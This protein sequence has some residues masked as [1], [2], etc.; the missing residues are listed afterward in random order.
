MDKRVGK[1]KELVKKE[2]SFLG[3]DLNWF[4]ETHLLAVEKCAKFLLQKLPKADKDLVMLLVWLHDLQRVRQI[5]GDHEKI[6]A[7]E[8]EKVMKDFDYN[9]E[10]IEKVKNA[11]LCH[12]CKTRMP[13][14]LEEKILATAD[15]MSQ[16]YNGF[17]LKI[18]LT[19]QRNFEEYK[20][21]LIEKLKRN[22]NKKIFFDFARKEIKPRHE[23]FKK[24][25]KV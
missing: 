17:F 11:I 16:Y 21:W 1:I 9:N 10:T 25:T 13:K 3:K 6:G 4:Y 8:A 20:E 23:F 15:A 24:L 12:R 22:Y 5:N 19:G 18:A 7:K 2:C 14:T